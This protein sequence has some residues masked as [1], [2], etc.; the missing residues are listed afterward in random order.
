MTVL[1]FL[2]L[3]FWCHLETEPEELADN[4]FLHAYKLSCF[5]CSNFILCLL[6]IPVPSLILFGEALETGYSKYKNPYH[7]L[8]H[9]ADV[10]HTVHCIMLL[11]GIMVRHGGLDR[12]YHLAIPMT[13]SSPS[14]SINNS[15]QKVC[16]G[17]SSLVLMTH[18]KWMFCY[19]KPELLT[20]SGAVDS[21]QQHLSTH[22][23]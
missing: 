20:L 1:L 9:A 22:L 15:K 12:F 21:Q 5:I 11:T 6:Q 14:L 3:V 19:T 7:N 2:I 8:I 4:V 18:P 23:V 10:T 16:I 13:F 17:T